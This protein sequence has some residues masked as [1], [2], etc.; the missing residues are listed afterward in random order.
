MQSFAVVDALSETELRPI[1]TVKMECTNMFFAKLSS[2][3]VTHDLINSN[4]DLMT[5]VRG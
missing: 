2:E 1:E 5:K 3:Q 4:D